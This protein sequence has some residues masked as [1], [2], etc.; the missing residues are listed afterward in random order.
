MPEEV[1]DEIL[2]YLNAQDIKEA[3][4]VSKHWYEVIGKSKICMEK[5][6]LKRG[7]SDSYE[8]SASIL[9]SN[10]LYQNTKAKGL[11]KLTL[12][13]YSMDKKSIKYVRDFLLKNTSLKFLSTEDS[14]IIEGLN[15]DNLKFKLEEFYTENYHDFHF[16][17]IKM[18]FFIAHT[19]SLKVVE[20]S[21]TRDY[22][23]FF[24]S[25]FPVLHTLTVKCAYSYNDESAEFPFNSTITNLRLKVA[26]YDILRYK[27]GPP[28][29]DLIRKLQNLREIEIGFI[30]AEIL[31]ALCNSRSL[32]TVKYYKIGVF[33]RTDFVGIRRPSNIKFIKVNGQN[34]FN[35]FD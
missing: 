20:C 11:E 17:I 8:F 9:E 30:N 21:L 13:L 1:C 25:N 16:S 29:T 24:M 32:K 26:F 31:K 12:D 34:E 18:D 28:I 5:M 27:Y 15:S 2:P 10:R 3:S 33:S 23:A 14:G 35:N 7:R 22:V 6:C 4:L 19:L